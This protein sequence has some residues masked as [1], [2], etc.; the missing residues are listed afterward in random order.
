MRLNFTPFVDLFSILAVGLLVIMTVTAG[1]DVV[2]TEAG[3]SS[4][5]IVK[6]YSGVPQ[7]IVG[8]QAGVAMESMLRIAPYYLLGGEEVARGSLP[9]LVREEVHPD[10]VEVVLR[11]AVDDIEVGFRVVEIR[12]PRVLDEEFA[13]QI[14]KIYRGI[15]RR[16]CRQRMGQWRDPVVCVGRSCVRG[17]DG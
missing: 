6:F 16:E 7:R 4:Q 10:S 9:A 8:Q 11:G 17:C 2:S 14:V 12:D 15:E 13:T 1:T 3:P 5:A